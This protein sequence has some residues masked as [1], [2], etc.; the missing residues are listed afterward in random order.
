MGS[1]GPAPT[2]TAILEARGSW[3]AGTREAEPDPPDAES[4]APCGLE[5]E[6]LALWN[7]LVSQLTDAKML[8]TTDLMMLKVLC[9]TYADWKAAE[10]VTARHACAPVLARLAREFGLT[11]SSRTGI[12]VEKTPAKKDGKRKYKLVG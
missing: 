6:A 5:G 1:R 4:S 3:R 11:P 2:P 8:K 12:V 10:T 9:Q 7:D